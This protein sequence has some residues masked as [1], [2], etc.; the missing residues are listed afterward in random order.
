MSKVEA[1]TSLKMLRLH[2]DSADE[3]AVDYSF[4]HCEG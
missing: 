1:C 2:F 4:N 3:F